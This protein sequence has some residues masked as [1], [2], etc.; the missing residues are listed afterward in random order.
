MGQV[1]RR[2]PG[3]HRSRGH[4][5]SLTGQRDDLREAVHHS[6]QMDRKA[7]PGRWDSLTTTF[8]MVDNQNNPLSNSGHLHPGRTRRTTPATTPSA[9]RGT[10]SMI[11][12][13]TGNNIQPSFYFSLRDRR[14]ERHRRRRISLEHRQLQHHRH[15]HAATCCLQ[16]PGNMVGPTIDGCRR[17]DCAGS[18]CLL[19]RRRTTSVHQPEEPEPAVLPSSRS[20]TLST[21]TTGKQNGRYCRLEG[22]ELHWLL[23][24]DQ[25]PATTSTAAS[26]RQRISIKGDRRSGSAGAFPKAIRLVE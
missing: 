19:G 12:A 13:G 23:H 1:L 11:R 4:G 5:R 8:D 17:A 2:A 16:E 21:T 6:R 7:G 14:H 9:T 18:G 25:S 15:G 20:T 24:R 26:S 3:E 22:G 10:R